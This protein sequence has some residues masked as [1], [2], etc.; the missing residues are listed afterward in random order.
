LA[1]SGALDQLSAFSD[2]AEADMSSGCAK[3]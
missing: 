3:S 1:L 2:Q